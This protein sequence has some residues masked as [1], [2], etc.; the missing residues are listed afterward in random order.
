MRFEPMTPETLPGAK[1]L[2]NSI[3]PRQG[4]GERLFFWAWER[5][6]RR[7][8]GLLVRLAGV[9]DLGFS[10]SAYKNN[11]VGRHCLLDRIQ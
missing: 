1:S 4:P 10:L 9:A 3:F 2:V 7:T 6:D 5:R 11:L 8:V